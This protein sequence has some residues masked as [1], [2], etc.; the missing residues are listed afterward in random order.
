MVWNNKGL[1]LTHEACPV[2][3]AESE[4]WPRSPSGSAGGALP[5]GSRIVGGMESWAPA[6]KGF[7][8]KLHVI[9]THISLAKQGI[10][11]HPTGLGECTLP[12]SSQGEGSWRPREQCEWPALQ[13]CVVCWEEAWIPTQRMSFYLL[14]NRN[15]NGI[16]EESSNVTN[17]INTNTNYKKLNIPFINIL[18][19][20]ILICSLNKNPLG[21]QR[22]LSV[23]LWID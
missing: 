16:F 5:S 7:G 14:R 1:F 11:W 2:G 13:G 3:L 17:I 15:Y 12:T 6:I 23:K 4:M 19:N 9:A 20:M 22:L 21:Q 8:H 10:W 18:C